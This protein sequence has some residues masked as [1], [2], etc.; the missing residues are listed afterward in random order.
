MSIKFKGKTISGPPGVGVPSGGTE[1]QILAK[2]SGD[3]YDVQW[4]DAPGE[5][6]STEETRIGTWIDGKPLYRKMFQVISPS[7]TSTSTQEVAAYTSDIET[8]ANLYGVIYPINGHTTFIPYYYSTSEWAYLAYNTSA[9]LNYPNS[10]RMAVG[11]SRTNAP[12]IIYL[13]YTKTTD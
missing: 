4:V 2:K 8:V 5:T 12:A 11:S 9:H 7:S 1:G 3:N 6:Y 13:E 10:L